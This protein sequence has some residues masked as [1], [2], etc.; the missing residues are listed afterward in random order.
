[1]NKHRYGEQGNIPYRV[2]RFFNIETNWYFA[3][4]DEPDE[5]PFDTKA[6]AEAALKVY[7]IDVTNF[8]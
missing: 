1:M 3:C 5:G 4:R 8:N 6:D 7:V 2:G